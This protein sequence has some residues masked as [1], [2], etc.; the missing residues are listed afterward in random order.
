MLLSLKPKAKSLLS[1]AFRKS[2]NIGSVTATFPQK[3]IQNSKLEICSSKAEWLSSWG[4][5]YVTLSGHP[6]A[7]LE[8]EEEP[9]L[10][11]TALAH[12]KRAVQSLAA[13][14]AHAQLCYKYK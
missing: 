10:L 4:Q 7:V 8:L 13:F 6:R 12:S 5:P 14:C 11:L 2:S 9:D 1:L 3:Q